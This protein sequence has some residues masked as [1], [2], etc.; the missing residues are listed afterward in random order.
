MQNMHWKILIILVAVLLAG[1]SIT[2][3]GIRKGKDLA[4]GLSLIYQ[5]QV[6]EDHPNPDQVVNQAIEVIK[7][8]VNPTGVLDISIT[9]LGGNRIEIVMPLPSPEVQAAQA[10]YEELI[11]SVLKKA[12]IDPV[13]LDMRLRDGTA[14]A[15]WGGDAGSEQHARLTTL[16]R[17]WEQQ[18]LALSAY[19]EA[20]EAGVTGAEMDRL[21]AALAQASVDYE[22]AEDAVLATSL[23]EGDLLRMLKLDDAPRE[24]KDPR[25][26]KTVVDKDGNPIMEPG[27]RTIEL[28]SMK[29]HYQHVADDLDALVTAYG[30]YT[31]KRKGFDDVE[32]LKR[33]LRGAGVLDFRIAVT[34]GAGA[35][36]GFSPDQLRQDMKEHGPSFTTTDLVKW[37]RIN[38]LKQ[39]YKTDAELASLLRD[40]KAYFQSQRGLEAG[41]YGGDIYLLLYD[42]PGKRLIHDAATGEWAL[43]NA[44][45]TADSFGRPAVQF[46]LDA[47]GGRRMRELTGP[48][49]QQPMAIVLDNEVFSAPNL[50]SQIGSNGIIEGNFT[51][52]EINYLIRVLSAGSLEASLDPEPVAQNVLGP[53]IGADNLNRGLYAC[54][55]GLVAVA[56]FMMAYYFFAGVVANIALLLNGVLIFGIMSMQ[57]A[58]FTLPGIAGIVLTIGM[59]VDANVLIYER[60]REEIFAGEKDLR[61]AIRLGYQK[62]FSTIID[63]NVTNLIICLVLYQTATAEV[64][65]FALTLGIGI[66]ATLFTALFVTRV[67]YAIYTD[68]FK[69]QSLPMLATVVPS[70]HRALEPNINWIG[71]RKIFVPLSL[72]AVVIS[73]ALVASRGKDMFDTD[74][75]GGL[76]ATFLTKPADAAEPEG[77]R[78]MLDRAEVEQR[79]RSIGTANPT[80]PLLSNFASASV[81][82]AGRNQEGGRSDSFQVKV[83]AQTESTADTDKL[84][85]ALV[86]EL[87]DSLAQT[88]PHE[89]PAMNETSPPRGT[90][91]VVG[92]ERFLGQVIGRTGIDQ[93]I[94]EYTGG[95]AIVIDD[96][97][98]AAR[99]ED[100]R[101]RIE[102]MRQQEEFRA[103]A[104]RKFDV[105]GLG[106]ADA[107]GAYRSIAI[108]VVDPLYAFTN[109]PDLWQSALADFEWR[110]V[111]EA[112]REPAQLEAVSSVSGSIATTLAANAEVAVLISL[113]G[114]LLYI[115]I[116][117]GSF[118]YS[119]AAMV[120]LVHDVSIALGLL[121]LTHFV[122]GTA[123]GQMLG[124]DGFRIDL[125]V[126]AALLTIIGYSLNDTIVILDRVRENRGKRPMADADTVNLSINQTISRTVLTSGTTLLAVLVMYIEGG[127]GIRPFAFCLLAGIFVGTYSSIAVAA[128]LVFVK[129]DDDDLPPE[130]ESA[131][132]EYGDTQP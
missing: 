42:V 86:E 81:L 5:L 18:A 95:V 130:D 108:V 37:F 20:V 115:W 43:V 84:V 93:R 76:T 127:T 125:G 100:V 105:F 28:E 72:V 70:V 56:I 91:F 77:P 85:A 15:T 55:F 88:P 79:I 8:R 4:G 54:I 110:L 13:E 120:A 57:Q 26:G 33:L 123:F 23:N 87:R 6:D 117:F 82:A 97:E 73:I 69:M 114:I 39:W 104:G 47:A 21:E 31:T 1:Y 32:D 80:D 14:V 67:I 30:D 25:T 3:Q 129:R 75:R 89:F 61:I 29:V 44:G 74:F 53:S 50:N 36:L 48:H 40:P 131:I 52:A 126:I 121:A 68:V 128:P 64:K 78:I 107:D 38:D 17:A 103:G 16:Q 118:R 122:G 92:D 59:A 63:A 71:L 113:L 111:T 94:G 83:A 49:V 34:S 51:P 132:V 106:E 62:A 90:T 45:R 27:P 124:L 60:I 65:G 2:R 66:L 12:R 41:E 96:L 46:T 35:S 116:R 112:L 98:P 99:V 19:E 101:H 9:P 119:L 10:K 102:R 7:D 58:A 11:A 109:N 22:A 24:K